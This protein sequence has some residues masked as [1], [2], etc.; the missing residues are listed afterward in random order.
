MQGL[1]L[2]ITGPTLI[3]LKIIT[4]TNYEDV[5]RAVSGRAFGFFIGAA[6]GGLLI[7]KLDPF[8]DVMLAICLDFIGIFGI[9]V[10]Y[11]SSTSWMFFVILLQGT[12]EGIINIGG[13]YDLRFAV[14]TF[15]RSYNTL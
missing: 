7:E 11:L 5:S 9:V 4:N 10:P 2:E 15:K 3:D 1:N 6:I 8:C 14:N 13:L 12:F